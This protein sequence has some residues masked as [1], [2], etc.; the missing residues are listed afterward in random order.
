MKRE[1]LIQN[2]ANKMI[3]LANAIMLKTKYFLVIQNDIVSKK[4]ITHFV[5]THDE[6]LNWHPE[7]FEITEK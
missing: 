4:S 2:K 7:N 1:Q 6:Y 3:A 5:E